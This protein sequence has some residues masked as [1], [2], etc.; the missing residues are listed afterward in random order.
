MS[1]QNFILRRILK[2]FDNF[3][4]ISK[5]VDVIPNTDKREAQ[6]ESEYAPKLCHKVGQGVDQLLRLHP[7]FLRHCPEREGKIFWLKDRWIPFPNEC[8][9]L[10]SARLDTPSEL[11]YLAR[12]NPVQ[13]II[14]SLMLPESKSLN[15]QYQTHHLNRIHEILNIEFITYIDFLLCNKGSLPHSRSPT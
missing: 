9:L 2:Y 6:E 13:T 15:F 12:L 11:L 1:V 4:A 8:V 5:E 10:V 14:F 7:S 3:T